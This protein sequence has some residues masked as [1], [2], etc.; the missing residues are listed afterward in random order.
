MRLCV[1]EYV[2]AFG[3]FL[4]C[5]VDRPRYAVSHCCFSTLGTYNVFAV[6]AIRWRILRF[7]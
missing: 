4:G 2:C 6:F 7:L 3:A 5:G 1:R